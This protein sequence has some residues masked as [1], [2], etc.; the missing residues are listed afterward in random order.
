[1]D[2]ETPEDPGA[3]EVDPGD[4]DSASDE[5]D[6]SPEI[7]VCPQCGHPNAAFRTHCR[8]CGGRVQGPVNL[9]PGVEFVE[10]APTD[11]PAPAGPAR[12]S[13][14]GLFAIAAIV[15]AG[16]AVLGWLCNAPGAGSILVALGITLML[17][18][19]VPRRDL[20]PGGAGTEAEP[21]PSHTDETCPECG[22]VLSDV[23]DICPHCGAFVDNLR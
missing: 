15:M 9:I 20:V 10:W 17:L 16:G 12:Q 3:N 5:P 18:A 6:D 8:R 1:M 13:S 14:S 7:I 22:G 21:V 23:D 11:K 19:L 4:S 2:E